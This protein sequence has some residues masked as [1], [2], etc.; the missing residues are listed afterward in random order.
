[1]RYPTQPTQFEM[2]SDMIE[3]QVH[4][5]KG[6]YGFKASAFPLIGAI[7][8]A[9]TVLATYF[10][11]RDKATPDVDPFPMTDITHC[12]IKYP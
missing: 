5:K 6:L 9:L 11:A 4:A 12:A 7:V 8:S 2:Q 10:V 3:H 1:M